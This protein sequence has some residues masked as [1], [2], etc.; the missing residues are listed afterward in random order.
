MSIDFSGETDFKG[1][2]INAQNIL[3]FY[4]EIWTVTLDLHSS[5]IRWQIS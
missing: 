3:E 2:E 1:I 5:V 4:I